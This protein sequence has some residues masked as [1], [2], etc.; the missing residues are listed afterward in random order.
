M[1]NIPT[2]CGIIQQ[3][4][5][6]PVIISLTSFSPRLPKLYLVIK[7]L[8]RQ[9]VKP[10]RIILYFGNDVKYQGLPHELLELQQYGLEIQ[11]KEDNLK[12]HKKYFYAMLEN[13]EAIVITVDDDFL[14]PKDM[15]GLLLKAH[16]QNPGC[17]VS[18][19]AHKM[20][21]DELGNLKPYT[22]WDW[23]YT[24]TR[25]QLKSLFS[26]GCGGCVYPPHLLDRSM[27]DANLIKELCLDADDVWLKFMEI[28]NNIKVK[29][30]NPSIWKRTVEI[31]DSQIVALNT[32]NVAESRNDFYINK[33]ME[34]FKIDADAFKD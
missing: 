21:F 22:M 16:E 13:P 32:T 20:Q 25:P 6:I 10:D 9:T 19:R 12:P 24:N 34:Y 11:F 26:T 29:L 30:A 7:S 14:Y 27:L 8:L 1:D 2:K 4:R 18:A 15:I 3:H 17:V 33:C 31:P 23:E 28:R 5:E